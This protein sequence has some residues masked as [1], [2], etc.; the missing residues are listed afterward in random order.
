MHAVFGYFA[1]TT[2]LESSQ[3]P[4]PEGDQGQCLIVYADR[5]TIA[6]DGELGDGFK[7]GED[8]G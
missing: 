7:T 2:D 3:V 4:A 8:I 5:L 6:P 1:T